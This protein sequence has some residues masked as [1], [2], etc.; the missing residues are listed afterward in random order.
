MLDVAYTELQS[1][2]DQD[3][4]KVLRNLEHSLLSGVPHKETIKSY[5]EL[6]FDSL[7]IQLSMFH[8]SYTYTTLNQAADLLR[9]ASPE[10]RH[11]FSQVS[12]LVRLMLV[13]PASSCEA[14]RSFSALRRLKTYL[15]STMTQK[16]LNNIVV[17]HVHSCRLRDINIQ[18]VINDFVS[19]NDSRAHLFGNV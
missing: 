10:I 14:E 12:I 2:F 17:C 4:F 19:L 1:R 18:S 3:S 5:P 7:S 6:Y 15:R 11:L 13:S 8:S 9:Q 16:R